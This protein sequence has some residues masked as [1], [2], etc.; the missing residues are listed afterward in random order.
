MAIPVYLQQFKAAGV[1]R[2][3]FD[4]SS[5]LNTDTQI[6]RLVVGYSERG[7]FNIPVY[8]KDPSEFKAY[9]GEPSK[10]LEK[11]G[12]Y[13]HRLAL[14]MLQV[15]P[16]LCLNLK[17]FDGETV[18]GSTISTDFNPRYEPIDTVQLNVEDI[19]NTVRFWEL[20][21]EKLNNLRAVNGTVLDQYINIATTN[22]KATSATYFI[23]KACGQKVS[24][25]NITVHN[26]YSDRAQEIPEFL[27]GKENN[28]ISDFF[29]EI[30]VFSGK[31]TAKQVLASETLKNYFVVTDELDDN[32]EPVLQLRDKVYDAFGDPVDTLD[33]LYKD[34]TSGALG[35][36]IG[37]LIPDFKNKQ[38]AYAAL[39][40]LFN[41]DHD[42]HNMM[43]SFNRDMLDEENVA[44]IDL[45]GRLSIPT[46]NAVNTK[47]VTNTSLS[48]AKIFKGEAKTNL[49][50]NLQSPVI[51]DKILFGTNVYNM[52]TK[53]AVVPLDTNGKTKIMGTLYVANVTDEAIP[54][55]A[56]KEFHKYVTIKNQNGDTVT[57]VRDYTSTGEPKTE[58]VL[59]QK[60]PAAEDLY[61]YV[62]TINCTIDDPWKDDTKE[63]LTAA[64]ASE[65]QT[66][67]ENYLKGTIKVNDQGKQEKGHADWGDNIY[68]LAFQITLMQVGGDKSEDLV[69]ITLDTK[70]DCYKLAAKLGVKVKAYYKEGDTDVEGGKAE[71]GQIKEL[72]LT[73]GFGTYWKGGD[74]FTDS[75][76]PLAGPEK[77]ITSITR[78][79]GGYSTTYDIFTDI[80]ENLKV[81]FLNVEIVTANEY[82]NPTGVGEDAVYGSSVS[83]IDYIDENW[84]DGT[85][86]KIGGV[87]GNPALV[88]YQYWDRSLMAVLQEGDCLLAKDGSVDYNDD[89]DPSNDKDFYYDNVY[90]QEIGTEYYTAED[91]AA[92]DELTS[93]YAERHQV[94]DFKFH[95]I[96]FTALPL[97][98]VAEFTDGEDTVATDIQNNYLVRIDGSLNQEIGLMRPQYLKG[99]VYKNDRP[100]GTGMYAKVQWQ[101]F[102]LSALTDYKGLRTGLLNKSEIDYRYVIDTFE[103]FPVTGLKDI[104]SYLCKEKQS[105]FCIANFPSVKNFIKCPYTSFTDSKGIF[106]VEYVVK[107]FNKKKAAS[108]KFSLPQESDGASFIAFYSPL[109]FSDGYIDSIIPSAGLVSNLFIEKYMS[110]QP[111]YIVAG[112]NYGRIV[113][114]GLVGPDYRY[115][116]DELQVI[117]PFGV[118]VMVYRPNF[119]TFINANQTAK[120]TP[121]S[122]LSKVHVR[123]L[124]IYL[125]DEIEKVLQAYQWEFNNQRTRNAILDKAN[126]ICELIMANG[127]I[128]AYRNIMDESNNTPE[129]I[130]N[131]MAI[132]S[133]HIEPGMGCGKMVQE[134]TLYRTGQMKAAL[135]D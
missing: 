29:A 30:Y 85:D 75:S 22:T 28:L 47:K 54:V 45:S 126:N 44:N 134:L 116:M 119:G 23:R 53:E 68:N 118:N 78:L 10:K 15:S 24:G 135:S 130:D 57:E 13:F 16:I 91:I 125:Q 58:T 3:V 17:K 67:T 94:G 2:V 121:L 111:Y 21:A 96:I 84:V 69:V 93:K 52:K 88:S 115:S 40:V 20:D 39:D 97:T 100:E 98:N 120:Q 26:W 64:D 105:A 6:L 27:E 42:V 106:N 131:E 113:A 103:S 50:G 1:Y 79:E 34:E 9:F 25:Y 33:T 32:D 61:Q 5:I 48:L 37:C 128:Q 66:N 117:E 82:V 41:N 114:S 122:A 76:D 71:E 62:E 124:V 4:K 63:P 99:Y 90:V 31:F 102:I 127:G 43:M 38:G 70:E 36:W 46:N 7:P 35:H 86:E 14:Q 104:L 80:D 87:T 11:R 109:K 83:F 73:E 101:N 72:N 56:A 81:N 51:A 49:M 107:G 123:E 92:E 65:A 132:L 108:M 18:D 55:I 112:P 77:V 60:F 129:I 95:Y 8:V 12:I 59:L 89:G 19:Y 74:A 133:T 110:R